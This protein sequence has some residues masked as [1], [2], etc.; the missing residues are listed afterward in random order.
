M[1]DCKRTSINGNVGPKQ[2]PDYQRHSSVKWSEPSHQVCAL[3]D[4]WCC[5]GLTAL[6]PDVATKRRAVGMNT[7]SVTQA[8]PFTMVRL[9]DRSAGDQSLQQQAPML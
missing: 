4:A 2:A 1:Q 3:I 9:S 7:Q 6:S 5:H 8:G